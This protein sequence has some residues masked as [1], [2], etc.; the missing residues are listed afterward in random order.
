M[1]TTADSGTNAIVIADDLVNKAL[2]FTGR[3]NEMTMTTVTG[4]HKVS[5]AQM[6]PDYDAGKLLTD[7]GMNR[8][9]ESAFTE[10][11]VQGRLDSSYPQRNLNFRH[12]SL[13]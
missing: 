8:A 4:S 12:V 9:M 6:L 7:A 2:P 3:R 10:Q 5:G 1:L 13:V 11:I